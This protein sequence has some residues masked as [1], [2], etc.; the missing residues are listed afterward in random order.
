MKNKSL[1]IKASV[2]LIVGY[3]VYSL[4]IKRGKDGAE[5][6]GG[7]SDDDT[8][9]KPPNGVIPAPPPP[10][11]PKPTLSPEAINNIVKNLVKAMD[12]Y[13]TDEEAIFAQFRR[14][15]NNLDYQALKKAFGTR[16]I[17]S[18]YYFNETTGNLSTLLRSELSSS[19]IAKINNILKSKGIS[20]RV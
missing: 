18:G 5:E 1:L 17:S 4:F 6:T 11:K 19:D 13:G 10:P 15:K 16:K 9:V 8:F 3:V 20:E 2:A 14:L 7:G 12:G